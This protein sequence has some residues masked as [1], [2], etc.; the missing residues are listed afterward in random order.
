[1]KKSLNHFFYILAE[2]WRVAEETNYRAV[3]KETEET[4]PTVVHLTRYVYTSHQQNGCNSS[5]DNKR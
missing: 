3:K 4:I 5:M 2:M 1:M